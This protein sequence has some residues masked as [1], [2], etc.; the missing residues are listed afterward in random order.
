MNPEALSPVLVTGATGQVGQR[1][2]G[3]LIAQGLGVTVLTRAPERAQALWPGDAV[4]FHRGDL[5]DPSSLVGLGNGIHTV[6]H[7]ASHHPGP[8][9]PDLYGAP[10]HWQ[11]SA[12]GTT[13]LLG[14]LTAAPIERLVYVSSVRAD[15]HDTLYGRAKRAAEQQILAFGEQRGIKASVLRLPMVYG[16][17]GTGNLER[18][19]R[20]IA[21]GR[22]PP[23]PRLAQRRSAIHVEDA[24]SALLL[25]ASHPATG[26]QVYV[27]TDGQAYSTRWIYEQTLRALG[28][29]LPSW[30]LPGWALRL[31]AEAGTF[32][33]R[34]L[35]RRMPLTR[36]ALAK[37]TQD[38]WYKDEGLR[39]L[40]FAARWDLESEIRRLVRGFGPASAP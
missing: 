9:E 14:A 23:W 34:V 36:E 19:V 22:F 6:L 15:T 4:R 35:K 38:A 33:E 29:P 30:T 17:D 12:E 13:H 11:V 3:T 26:G 31:A 28:R 20:A 7:L 40:G 27:A 39:A 5:T 16:L 2:V 8:H 24:I 21:A 10:G 32:A 1:L 25:L 18:L 37:L